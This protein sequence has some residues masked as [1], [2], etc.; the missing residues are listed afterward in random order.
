MN[1]AVIVAAGKGVRLAEKIGMKK[2]FYPLFEQ[3]EMLLISLLP[4]IRLPDFQH[5]ILVI[6]R[7]DENRVKAILVREKISDQVEL[8]FGQEDR[9]SSVHSALTYISTVHQEWEKDDTYV[10]IH[11]G[12]RPLVGD[13][14]LFR[15]LEASKTHEAVIPS[16]SIKDSLYNTK[17]DRYAI[18]SDYAAIQTPQVF[19]LTLLQEA[20][21]R[22]SSQEGLF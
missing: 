20:F 4:F 21:D 18:R 12:D 13:E 2:Q 19:K 17:E 1:I 16:I 6:P 15:L 3:K 9:E 22:I 7:E 5:I 10:F 11:D 14:L 8:A